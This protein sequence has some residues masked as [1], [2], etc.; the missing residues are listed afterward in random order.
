[1]YMLWQTRTGGETDLLGVRTSP[2]ENPVQEMKGIIK[3]ILIHIGIMI[4]AAIVAGI[5][6]YL[7]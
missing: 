3:E 1:M 6:Y 2:E 7:L 5:V 4:Y